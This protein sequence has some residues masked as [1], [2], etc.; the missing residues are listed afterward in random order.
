MPPSGGG[1]G[2][3]ASSFTPDEDALGMIMAMGFTRDQA[4]RALKETVSSRAVH[5]KRAR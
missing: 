3:K 5:A 4:T 2:K 1:G